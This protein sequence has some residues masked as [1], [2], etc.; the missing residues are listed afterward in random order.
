MNTTDVAMGLDAADGAEARG[1]RHVLDSLTKLLIFWLTQH[2]LNRR[3]LCILDGDL[4][5]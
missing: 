3:N 5:L 2:H 4:P 1:F